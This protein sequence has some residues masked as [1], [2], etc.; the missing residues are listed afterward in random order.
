MIFTRAFL[1]ESGATG[2]H[3]SVGWVVSGG[4]LLFV[5]VVVVSDGLLKKYFNF[6]GICLDFPLTIYFLIRKSRQVGAPASVCE[7][8]CAGLP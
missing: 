8:V 6:F 5:V 2:G 7:F 1:E 4:L 3:Y